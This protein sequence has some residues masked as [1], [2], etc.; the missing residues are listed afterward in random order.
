MDEEL[1]ELKKSD[2]SHNIEEKNKD[3]TLVNHSLW[4][5]ADD[6]R[7]L[8]EKGEFDTYREAYQWACDNYYKKNVKLTVKN[9]ERAYFK[10]VSEG[11][12][13]KKLQK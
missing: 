1:K 11:R 3:K 2:R 12:A 7:A 4:A 13:S 9:L 8:K 10:Y 6:M 5:I